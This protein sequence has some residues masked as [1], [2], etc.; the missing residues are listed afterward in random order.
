MADLWAAVLQTAAFSRSFLPV[1]A[2]PVVPQDPLIWYR[3]SSRASLCEY[4]RGRQPAARGD[5]REWR[6]PS[7]GGSRG[8][9][10]VPGPSPSSAVRRPPF[11]ARNIRAGARLH[12]RPGTSL[13]ISRTVIFVYSVSLLRPLDRRSVSID[14]RIHIHTACTRIYAVCR[15]ARRSPLDVSL[16]WQREWSDEGQKWVRLSADEASGP[17]RSSL[18]LSLSSPHGEGLC[19][20]VSPSVETHSHVRVGPVGA[21]APPTRLESTLDDGRTPGRREGGRHRDPEWAKVRD[22]CHERASNRCA[23]PVNGG[24]CPARGRRGW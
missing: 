21:G 4:P 11:A 14:T 3:R 19:H 13:R 5:C 16:P 17:K 1:R 2:R 9:A 23:G 18:S 22:Q 12:P 15:L 7:S 10:R 20:R 8:C 6:R 24:A